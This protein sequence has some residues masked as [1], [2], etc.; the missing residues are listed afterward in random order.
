MHLQKL[1]PSRYNIQQR[2]F[3][4]LLQRKRVLSQRQV[5]RCQ[6]GSRSRDPQREQSRVS[7][8]SEDSEQQE[9]APEETSFSLGAI[10]RNAAKATA[11]AAL[12]LAAVW[13]LVVCFSYDLL[14]VAR[15]KG[16]LMIPLPNRSR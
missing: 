14:G 6:L 11:I 7:A 2:S 12:I 4:I 13:M 3:A 16:M 9:R 15:F 5:S 1:V 8:V 10:I